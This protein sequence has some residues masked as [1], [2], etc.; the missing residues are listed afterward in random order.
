MIYKITKSIS[1]NSWHWN[2]IEF[3]RGTPNCILVTSK[4]G[5]LIFGC[6]NK[7]CVALPV[8]IH[9]IGGVPRRVAEFLGLSNSENYTGHCFRQSDENT[10][11]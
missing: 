10:V 1:K 7:K 5:V 6:R 9:T 11:V 2:L 4:I 3:T 8:D